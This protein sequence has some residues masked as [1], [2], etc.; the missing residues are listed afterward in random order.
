MSFQP[1]WYQEEA[2]AS[3]FEYYADKSGNP[4]I[5]MPTGT[6]KS[7]VIAQFV[8][9]VLNQ[10]PGQRILALT[11]V[12]EL[13]A[14]N[15]ATLVRLWPDAPAG[16]FSAGLRRREVRP[17]TF[18][19]I[20]SVRNKASLLG[21]VDL[22]LIDEAHLVSPKENTGYQKLWRELYT[23]NQNI[24]VIGFSATP[25]RLKQGLLTEKGGL[26]TDVCYDLTRFDMFNQ[27]IAE[28]WLAQLI[29]KRVTNALNVDG[30]SLTGGDYNLAELQ[31]AVDKEAITKRAVQEMIA[32]GHDR[33][34]WLVFASGTE[35]SDHIA[36]CLNENGI[37]AAS[38][39]SSMS[40]DRDQAIRQFKAGKL[41]ALVNN[42]IL[43]TGFDAPFIDLI[44]VLRPT[45]S[46]GL[47]VQ[48]LG[49][50]TRPCAGKENCLV[51][52]FAGNTAQLGP[53]NDPKI[54]KTGKK[55]TG[56]MPVKLCECG[57]Y[58]HLRNKV[59]IGC[60]A[61]FPEGPV[62]LED[63][64]SSLELISGTMPVVE[65]FDVQR[66]TYAERRKPDAPKTIKISY[67]CALNTFYEWLCFNHQGLAKHKSN[68]WWR[69][70]SPYP[71]PLTTDDAMSRISELNT[72]TQIKVWLNRKYPQ[73]I[74]A[75]FGQ[76]FGPVDKPLQVQ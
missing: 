12:K 31:L 50:G 63:K 21:H 25:F 73:V 28:G 55:K 61:Q 54:P 33:N 44:A 67:H 46:P 57:V 76:D 26:F 41:R 62:C 36:Q 1:R 34:H 13:I 11:H 19:G 53:I 24:K 71:P 51:L 5:A 70:R 74:G 52:D 64:A 30:V 29:P 22:M 15:H 32:E 38:V 23:I 6:G 60:G 16:I 40:G 69:L 37:Q 42:N 17:V 18:G 68:L 66:V 3:I 27:L 58:N 43:T 10:W 20:G 8:Q 2:V 9:K 7:V 39:H 72:P 49:R 35:H 4:L 59:C 65:T 56:I 75:N 48:M 47:W 45:K 14:Q